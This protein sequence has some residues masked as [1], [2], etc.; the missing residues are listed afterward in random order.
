M[1]GTGI[2]RLRDSRET[3]RKRKGW[4]SREKEEERQIHRETNAHR[5]ILYSQIDRVAWGRQK[6]N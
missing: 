5:Y 2:Q 6:D 1:L 3:E 4:G